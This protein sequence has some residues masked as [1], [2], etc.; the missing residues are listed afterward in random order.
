MAKTEQVTAGLKKATETAEPPSPAASS[1]TSRP[2]SKAEAVADLVGLLEETR[3]S[4]VN[5]CQMQLQ[6]LK[7]EKEEKRR[8]RSG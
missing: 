1:S 7:K 5:S 8:S 6:K 2:K 4:D 3:Q